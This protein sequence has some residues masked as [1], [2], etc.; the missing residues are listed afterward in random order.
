MG[1]LVISI[2]I[3]NSPVAATTYNLI[4]IDKDS[5]SNGFAFLFCKGKNW[6]FKLKKVATISVELSGT[7]FLSSAD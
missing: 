7:F 4:T 2:H 1:K 6:R 5:A 3:C